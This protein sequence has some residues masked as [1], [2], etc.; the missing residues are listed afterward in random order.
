MSSLPLVINGLHR[1]GTTMTERLFDSQP[2]VTCFNLFFQI[3]RAIAYSRGY[4]DKAE[5]MTEDF[6]QAPN[7]IDEKNDYY[8]RSHF[9]QDYIQRVYWPYMLKSNSATEGDLV[10]GLD[11]KTL[12]NFVE[13]IVNHDN[14]S[15]IGSLLT[16]IGDQLGVQICATRWTAHHRY[17]PVFLKNPRAYW[18]EV[19]RNPY[20]RISS[21]RISHHGNFPIVLRQQ[22]DNLD[23][24]A[25]FKHDRYKVL[26]YEHLC[27]DTDRALAEVSE[28]LGVSITNQDLI[29]IEGKPFRPNTS[30]NPR[31][32]REI[33]DGDETMPAR[34]G[35]LDQNRWRQHVSQ[36]D[37]AALNNMLNFHGLYDIEPT[38]SVA[39]FKGSIVSTKIRAGV[40]LKNAIKKTTNRFGF[41]IRRVQN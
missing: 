7:I 25:N 29:G 2:D 11:R 27:N 3:I 14:L 1:S 38:S 34:I 8:V 13:I 22:Q 12:L 28:W 41:A 16:K 4:R 33:Y 20:A 31:K 30:D 21:E 10:F 37:I 40:G 5:I 24:V 15:D 35:A 23:F 26:K 19:V 39:H 9:L 32:G 17:A 18:L 6:E 36:T